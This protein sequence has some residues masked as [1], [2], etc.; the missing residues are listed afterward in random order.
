MLQK[1]GTTQSS[2]PCAEVYCRFSLQLPPAGMV[3]MLVQMA[4]QRANESQKAY[5]KSTKS[6]KSK[7]K[8]GCALGASESDLANLA[9]ALVGVGL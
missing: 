3:Q 6:M 5:A 2:K 7:K 9:N 4:G 1:I 8:H